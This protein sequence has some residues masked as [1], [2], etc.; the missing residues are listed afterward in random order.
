MSETTPRLPLLLLPGLL[1]DAAVWTAQRDALA[2]LAE[3]HVP[4]YG[5]LDSLPAMAAHV[6]ATAPQPRF[7]LA[8]HSMGGRV[9]LEVVRQAPERVLGLALLDT[10]YQ[11]LPD[12]EAGARERS[13]RMALLAQ[14]R[15]EGMRAM[16]RQWARGM[17][18]P[19]RLAAPLFEA[20]LDMIERSSPAQFEAQITALL[21]RPDA[22][23]LL[24]N[25]TCPVLLQCGRDD[26]WSPL[27]RHE[28]ML[29]LLPTGAKIE[30]I[31]HA[32]HMTTM[33]QPDAVAAGLARWL[34]R[35]AQQPRTPA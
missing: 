8:G 28:A 13:G 33:E 32:G 25:I 4:A 22:T 7:A 21:A 19:D 23:P 29:G 34:R 18:H 20:I 27:A 12:G 16:G 30:V 1:C 10:G 31:E 17:V 26:A 3:M 14:A 24:A 11:P 15:S 35:C 6:L 9:A 5:L 2:P